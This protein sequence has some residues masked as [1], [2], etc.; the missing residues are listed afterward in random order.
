VS[1]VGRFLSRRLPPDE[2]WSQEKGIVII[3]IIHLSPDAR[4]ELKRAEHQSF[5]G[6]RSGC[7]RF[8]L[9]APLESFGLRFCSRFGSGSRSRA[10][11]G[12]QPSPQRPR[13]PGGLRLPSTAGRVAWPPT[14]GE[15]GCGEAPLRYIRCGKRAVSAITR[16][17]CPLCHPTMV[18][19]Y[20][21]G[22][23]HSLRQ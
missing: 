2:T 8:G 23:T 15:A 21:T 7:R 19:V 22:V 14:G 1:D 16:Y 13:P 18:P 9:Y 5:R 4:K 17:N 10:T 12:G 3:G 11:C 6:I 20:R